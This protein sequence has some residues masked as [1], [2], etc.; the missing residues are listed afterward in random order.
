MPNPVEVEK[1]YRELINQLERIASVRHRIWLIYDFVKRLDG[2]FQK[3]D[4]YLLQIGARIPVFTSPLTYK[5]LD[6]SEVESWIDLFVK[7]RQSS[8][9]FK[10]H[11]TL[12]SSLNNLCGVCVLQYLIVE[13]PQSAIRGVKKFAEEFNVK[14]STLEGVGNK[15]PT[16]SAD[17][18]LQRLLDAG[19]EEI[20]PFI[21]DLK[22]GYKSYVK[23]EPNRC[24]V[25]VVE[26]YTNGEIIKR[27]GRLRLMTVDVKGRVDDETDKFS[28]T[29][30][31]VGSSN[32]NQQLSKNVTSAVRDSLNLIKPSLK[33]KHFE[34]VLGYRLNNVMQSGN[35]SDAAS[36]A[37]LVSSIQKKACKREWIELLSRVCIT[38]NLDE[39][40][41]FQNVANEGIKEKVEAAF[42][43]KVEKL[44]VPK[45]QLKRFEKEVTKLNKKYPNRSLTVI[46]VTELVE[47]F[48]DRRL[49]KEIKVSTFQYTTGKLWENRY[50]AAGFTVVAVMLLIIVRLLYGPLDQN[51]VYSVVEGSNVQFKNQYGATV[52]TLHVGSDVASFLQADNRHQP[53][54]TFHDVTGD[55]LN[56]IFWA[57]GISSAI[58]QNG[59]V[60]AWS[61]SGDSLIWRKELHFD[62][63]FPRQQGLSNLYFHVN[64]IGIARDGR[65]EAKLILNTDGGIYFP[66]VVAK[67]NILTGEVESYYTHVG[68]LND[69]ALIDLTGDGRDEVILTGVNNAFWKASL[70]VLD[71]DNITGHSPTQGDHIISGQERAAEHA[72]IMIPKTTI[73]EFYSEVQKYT[74]GFR[75]RNREEHQQLLIYV[76]EVPGREFREHDYT[77]YKIFSFNYDLTLESIFTSDLYDILMQELHE[78]GSLEQPLDYDYFEA[79]KDSVRYY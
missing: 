24:L 31:T 70:V 17:E 42:F 33:D 38:G 79:F 61:V 21:S 39:N 34:A 30:Y 23:D 9:E 75:V 76:Q 1:E 28:K 12:K 32:S 41:N 62:V 72:Y 57:E 43:S 71:L 10:N 48:Y 54:I 36:A 7:L 68:S 65:D 35:S 40:G 56:E 14:V 44:V 49:S 6:P 25:P 22:A 69:M 51:P 4:S 8:S 47:I 11:S 50:S 45:T 29:F 15:L 37:L 52:K 13:E 18:L 67:L 46:G 63:E 58:D 55:G 64:E 26:S 3:F 53:L 66:G 59:A 16:G 5:G 20:R 74:V 27:Y 60:N 2:Q 73:G 78:E 19:G 77:P